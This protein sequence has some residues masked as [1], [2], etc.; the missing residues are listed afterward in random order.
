MYLSWLKNGFTLSQVSFLFKPPRAT[1]SRY[2]NTWKDFLY[3]S[4]ALI[5]IWP[6][7]E[8]INEEMS[9]IV[10]RT[11]RFTRC[12]LDW[13]EL[14]CQRPSSLSTQNLL[15]VH[16]KIHAT[17]KYLI[18]ISPSGSIAVVSELDVGSNLA[19]SKSNFHFL[20]TMLW[21]TVVSQ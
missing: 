20:G 17:Y 14:Y 9:E 10:K 3:F 18:D 6:T 8:Q 4:C 11:Y 5:A 7:R 21:R 12:I 19:S 13:A 2:I 1:V 16:Y 15:Y